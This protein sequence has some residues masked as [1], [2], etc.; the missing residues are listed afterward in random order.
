MASRGR[1]ALIALGAGVGVLVLFVF[2]V[3]LI[4]AVSDDGLPGGAG[5]VVWSKVSGPGGVTFGD[6][7]QLTTTAI[8]DA[9]GTYV[10]R[11]TASDGSPS[12]LA[13]AR[14]NAERLGL[15]VE[16][17]EGNW[18]QP[19]AGNRF[20]LVLSNPPYVAGDDTHLAA[21]RDIESRLATMQPTSG[22]GASACVKPPRPALT[23]SAEVMYNS[24]GMEVENSANDVDVPMRNQLIRDLVVAALACDLSR[25]ATMMLAPSRSDIFFNFIGG[26]LARRI[27]SDTAL[28]SRSERA[29]A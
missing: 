22:G 23:A 17:V 26:A 29:L 2:T 1:V 25:V 7:S 12:A 18:W 15:A 24:S 16:F 19:L 8:F 5:T 10:L 4:L 11:L 9:A 27:S 6:P 21:L 14:G 3:W 28:P 13:V 20:D